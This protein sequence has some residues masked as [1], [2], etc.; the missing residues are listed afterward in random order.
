M[1][2]KNDNLVIAYYESKDAAEHAAEGLKDWDKANDSI[3]LGAIAVLYLGDKTGELLAKEIGERDAKKGAL[4][5]AGIGVVA[6]ILT[7]GIGLIPGLLIG[8]AAGGGLGALNHKSVGLSD[9]DRDML[10][11]KLQGGRAALAVMAD[12]FEVESTEAE[13]ARLGGQT[14]HYRVPD[15]TVTIIE[16]ASELQSQAAEA[17]DEAVATAQEEVVEATRS[18]TEFATD[19][20]EDA[21]AALGAVVAATGITAA[22]ASKLSEAG[23]DSPK[24][25][26]AMG[27]TPAGRAELAKDLDMD[28]SEVLNAVKHLDLMRVKGVGVKYS[29]LLL[30]AGVDT[31]VELGTRNAANLAAKMGEVNEVTGLVENLPTADQVSEW[32]GQAKELPRVIEY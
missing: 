21:T 8:G 30:A 10:V 25:L 16:Q 13:L 3:K 4:W 24:A 9:E 6:G 28:E 15:E 17:I 26:L 2:N 1:T 12:S 5:G 32:V 14:S 23:I 11:Q 31:V 19:L 7:A 22:K 20:G 18:V 27:A 29:N